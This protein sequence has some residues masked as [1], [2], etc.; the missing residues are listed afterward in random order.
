MR[1]R[2]IRIAIAAVALSGLLF[3][4]FLH[5]GVSAGTSNVHAASVL[6][7]LTPLQRRI[8]SGFADNTLDPQ[9]TASTKST[10]LAYHPDSGD[11]QCAV[12]LGSNIKVNQNCLNLSDVTLQGRGQANNETAIAVN[13]NNANDLV[14]GNN[15]YRRGDGNCYGAYSLDNANHWNDTTIP[16]GFTSGANF[17]GVQRQ[18]WQAGGDTSVAWDTKG[19]V[20]FDCQMFM[21][22]GPPVT[23]NPDLS[24]AVYVFRSTHNDG[25]S[26]NFPGRPVVENNDVTSTSSVVLE[27]KPY[28]TVDNHVGSPFQDR[29]YVT[30]TAFAADGSAYIFESYSS[31]YGESFSAPVVVSTTSA[32]CVNTFGA[33]TPYGTCNE[34]QFSDPFTGPDGALYVVYANFNNATSSATDNHNQ[35]LLS[36]STDGGVTFSAPVLVANYNDL[37]DCA[38]YQAGQDAGR[39]CVP[40]KGSAT[41]SVFRATNY[42]SGQVD[43]TNAKR[44][45]VTFGSYIN[46]DSNPSNGCVPAGFAPSGNNAYTGVKTPG[47]CNNKILESVSTNSGTSFNGTITDPTT[48]TVVSSAP[49]QKLTDQWWQWSAFTT[50]G[51]LE[52]SYYDRQYGNDETSGNMDF[53][54]SSSVNDPTAFKV[55][56]VT[57]SSMPLPTEFNDAQGNSLFFGDYTGLAASANFAYPVWMD[58]RD[59]D[60]ALCPGTGAPGVPPQVCTFT[61]PNGIQANDQDIFMAKV[62]V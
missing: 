5:F 36:K 62:A 13:P 4:A 20:Y 60:L 41:N 39:A 56:R 26:W 17:G 31:D 38:T 27:D 42:P 59:K 11:D 34:N 50:N 8:V 6:S 15:D 21:R 12:S 2:T 3:A 44:V 25:A 16:M 24:S 14:V 57:S 53:S 37:P 43:P 30:W 61:E 10:A 55:A 19:N 52:V 7:Q 1:N 9:N 28:M 54:L 23:N 46:K 22:G 51:K 45:I 29:V 35:M 48:L 18:Y 47:A 32:L 40:E 49:G 33:G 58:T